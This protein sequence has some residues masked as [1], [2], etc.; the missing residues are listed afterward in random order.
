MKKFVLGCTVLFIVF[1]ARTSQ[2]AFIVLNTANWGAGRLPSDWQI[3][4]NHGKPE[5]SVCGQSDSC[6][7][8]KCVRSSFALEHSVDVDPSQMPFL[9]WRWNVA[10]LPAGGDFRHMS[11]DD[12]A[13][14]V[15]VGFADRRILSYIWDTSAPKG[16]EQSASNL[17][18]LHVFAV[19]CESGVS[20]TN[21]WLG[22]SRNVA[23]DYQ[24]AYGKPAPRVKGLRIQINSQ[25]TGTTAESYFGEVAFRNVPQE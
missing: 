11:T 25:H 6:L 5:I 8:L 7:H 22:E 21:H 1:Q 18:L 9:T 20:Q 12:Q 16:S 10:Q 17:P 3:K 15:L 24:R 2:L 13:A 14:Q 4:V 23:A 19:V